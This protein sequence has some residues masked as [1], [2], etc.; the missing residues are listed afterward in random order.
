MNIGVVFCGGCQSHFDRTKAYQTIDD[1]VNDTIEYAKKHHPYIHLIV[2]SGCKAACANLDDYQYQ[3]LI[4]IKQSEDIQ[5][6]IREI[7]KK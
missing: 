3:N 1:S 2:I 7:S 4:T 6:A 5:T